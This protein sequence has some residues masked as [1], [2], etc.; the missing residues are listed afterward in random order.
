M[1]DPDVGS[2]PFRTAHPRPVRDIAGQDVRTRRIG[3]ARVRWAR[4]WAV[5]G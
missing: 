2:A 5:R 4:C 1:T 3:D